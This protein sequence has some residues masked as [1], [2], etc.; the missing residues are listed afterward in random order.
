MSLTM[1]SESVL[2]LSMFLHLKKLASD[3]ERRIVDADN[4]DKAKITEVCNELSL[5]FIQMTKPKD[6][7]WTSAVMWNICFL[8]NRAK[9]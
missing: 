9:L 7:S 2:L 6:V 8:C 5:A 1:S 4:T 3:N